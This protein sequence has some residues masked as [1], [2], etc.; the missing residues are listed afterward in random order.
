ML[1]RL[2]LCRAVVSSPITSRLEQ[3]DH[4]LQAYPVVVV[5]RGYHRR[6]EIE[7]TDDLVGRV[8]KGHD[9]R[10]DDFRFTFSIAG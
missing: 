10:N 3:V 5:K 2:K 4:P 6:V 9:E 7:H 8:G 1:C